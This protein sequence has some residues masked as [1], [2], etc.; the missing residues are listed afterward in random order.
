MRDIGR[1]PEALDVFYRQH[2][3]AI[4]LF[5]APG[6][7]RRSPGGYPPEEAADL[8]A[9]IFVAAI[10]ASDHCRSTARETRAV[11]RIE[12]RALLD[13]DAT[14]RISQR[15]DDQRALRALWSSL[16]ALPASPRAWSN[17]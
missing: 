15:I 10:E 3:S 6:W 1:D 14:E 9:D 4:Q 17:S 12:G 7:L 5:V 13:D 11:R 2:L 8:T 16:A